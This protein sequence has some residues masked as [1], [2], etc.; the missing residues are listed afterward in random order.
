MKNNLKI[1]FIILT[2][3]TALAIAGVGAYRYAEHRYHV[4]QQ[5][6][7]QF[8]GHLGDFYDT[9]GNLIASTER[10]YGRYLDCLVVEDEEEW[11][12]KTLALAPGLASLFPERSAAGWWEYLQEGRRLGKRYLPIARGLSKQQEDSLEALPL[13]NESPFRGG[14]IIESYL[15]RT[16]PYDSLARRT[17]GYVK[18][19]IAI[20]IEG[21]YNKLLPGWKN[22]HARDLH[23]TLDMSLQQVAD[24]AL[25][26][27]MGDDTH[28]Q[29]GCVVVMDVRSGAVRAM[30][31][32]SRGIPSH[33]HPRLWE[34]YNDAIAHLYEPGEVLQT[35]ALASA[36]RDGNLHSLDKTIPTH[37]GE[38]KHYQADPRIRE[39]E[40]ENNATDI[41]VLKGFCLSS[42]YVMAYLTTRHYDAYRRYYVESVRNYCL[43]AD[44]DLDI[45]GLRPV[46]IT[47][48]DGYYWTHS[49]LASLANGFSLVMAPLDILSF[50]NT[51]A[52]KG[53]MV[54]PFLVEA[55]GD[56][57]VSPVILKEDVIPPFVAD[58]LTRALRQVVLDG[59]A[60]RLK[61]ARYPVAGKTGTASQ[62][63][64]PYDEKGLAPDPY[65]DKDGRHSTAATFA[66]FFPADD[67]QYSIICVIYSNPCEKTYFGGGLPT[68]VVLDVVNSTEF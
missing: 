22:D 65:H 30:A 44:I 61:K 5:E 32:L 57:L 41:S 43:P 46:D 58:T 10:L 49:T 21:K 38:L 29:A 66:G 24:S 51:I 67:P 20:G 52:N 62:I 42:P 15:Q 19:D 7:T 68:Q 2:S 53:T 55:I 8:Y 48:P 36:L 56:S 4:K 45:E 3:L 40:V 28:L 64:K 9:H 1:T 63:I 16:Y 37:H 26:A 14:G 35:M 59:T 13:F 6:K 17:L 60:V 23:L 11:K 50:Y 54:K 47:Y 25:R 33:E 34:R 39:Y 12:Q 31:N 27:A 18:G